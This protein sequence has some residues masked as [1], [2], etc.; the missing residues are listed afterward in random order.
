MS[1][2]NKNL[3]GLVYSTNPD[4]RPE[5]PDFEEPETWPPAMQP[6]RVVKD[7]K[8]RAGKIVT[9]VTGFQGKAD[10]LEALCKKLKTKCG[11]GGSAKDGY[12]LIQGDY[13]EKIIAGLKEWGYGKAH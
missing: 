10:D 11:T 8:Q 13:K 9:L 5:Q 4:F 6:L 12:V 1:A 7:T 2:K 3:S